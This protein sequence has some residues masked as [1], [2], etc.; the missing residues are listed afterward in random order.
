MAMVLNDAAGESALH[1]ILDGKARTLAGDLQPVRQLVEVIGAAIS[2]ITDKPAN[3]Q[4]LRSPGSEELLRVLAQKGALLREYL[5]RY[6]VTDGPLETPEYVQLV[7]TMPG[8]TFP[9]EFIYDY[10]RPRPGAKICPLAEAA[11]QNG[12]C[13]AACPNH[14]DDG[15]MAQTICPYGFWGLRCVV[16]RRVNDHRR[17]ARK[18]ANAAPSEPTQGNRE[19]L[20]PLTSVLVG[21]S[22]RADVAVPNS[23]AGML[24]RIRALEPNATQVSDWGE[25]PKEV[26]RTQ[27]ATLALVVH[28]DV[29]RYRTPVIEIGSPPLPLLSSDDLDYEYVRAPGS[30]V[31]PIV[32]LVGCETG[33]AVVSYENFATRFQWRDAA[34]VVSTI[35]EVLGRQAA[36][37]TAEILEA[38]RQVQQPTS[39]AV[40]M[41]DVRRKLLASGTPMVLSLLADGDADWLVQG[42]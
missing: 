11:L 8:K 29:N 27:P 26:A 19:V 39:F 16:E 13:V 1:L 36:P 31:H 23:V 18:A 38:I 28:Q 10:R 40:V 14:A 24:A 41:R 42:S 4:G 25:W 22:P 33:N 37:M 35:A 17:D 21:A 9:L 32:L 3:Y 20:R 12:D 15:A 30:G 34:L 5:E 7:S 2:D 6:V